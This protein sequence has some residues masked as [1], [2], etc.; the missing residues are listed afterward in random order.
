MDFSCKYKMISQFFIIMEFQHWDIQSL[1]D[2][3]R[4]DWMILDGLIFYDNHYY[5]N[6]HAQEK[7]RAMLN[8][9]LFA[10]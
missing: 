4:V 9:K 5:N 2:E 1:N 6:I 7:K 10:A 3:T 8:T